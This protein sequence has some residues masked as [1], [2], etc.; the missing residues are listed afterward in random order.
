MAVAARYIGLKAEPREL[1][2][3]PLAVVFRGAVLPGI[4]VRRNGRRR[5]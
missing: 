5:R 2:S 4:G 1:G 3:I